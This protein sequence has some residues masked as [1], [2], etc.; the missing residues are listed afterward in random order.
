MSSCIISTLFIK[1]IVK[2]GKDYLHLKCASKTNVWTRI[3]LGRNVQDSFVTSMQK[4]TEVPER[5]HSAILAE[6][7]HPSER[8]SKDHFT[9]IFQDED[10]NHITTKHV[11]Q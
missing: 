4:A 9:T 5:A 10:G 3:L 6:T 2:D 11:Y 1:T 8:D 7:E